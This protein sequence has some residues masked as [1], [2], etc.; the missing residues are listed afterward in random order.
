[1]KILRKILSAVVLIIIGLGLLALAGT[2]LGF[3][4]L[5][6]MIGVPLLIVGLILLG[7]GLF[8]FVILGAPV[9]ILALILKGVRW[10]EKELVEAKK[11]KKK[12]KQSQAKFFQ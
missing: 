11:Y 6:A 1:M 10:I 7:F 4:A 12:R 5:S 9:F 3:L 8:L 2:F